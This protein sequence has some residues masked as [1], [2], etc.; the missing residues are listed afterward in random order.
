MGP[1][2][3]GKVAKEVL[4]YVFNKAFPHPFYHNFL[5]I[6]YSQMFFL[7]FHNICWCKSY[8][9]LYNSIESAQQW[10][11]LGINLSH[12]GKMQLQDFEL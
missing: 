2:D 10:E 4:L 3:A 12:F 11:I 7:S 1:F 5:G 9:I 8:P 6:E